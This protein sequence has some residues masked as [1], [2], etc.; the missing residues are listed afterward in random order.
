VDT[1][2]S[3][4]D[5]PSGTASLNI[6]GGEAPYSVNWQ[7]EDPTA[8]NQGAYSVTV[9]DDADCV[10]TNDFYIDLYPQPQA[11][12]EIDSILMINESYKLVNNSVGANVFNWDFNSILFNS[13]EEN[14][15][16]SYPEE[17]YFNISLSST[18]QY[19]CTDTVTQTIF[20]NRGIRLYSPN[21]FTPN[22]DS[23]NDRLNIKVLYFTSFQME[24]YSRSGELMFKPQDPLETW[25]GTFN[26]N[27][28]PM[29]TYIAVISANDLF[30]RVVNQQQ[31][32]NLIR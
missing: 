11:L 5:I 13:E 28:A 3:C 24:V 26:N 10:V 30:G 8:L 21:S 16:I 14:P 32:I 25:D 9:T 27:L 12:F 2:S 29:G 15:I 31:T 18:S 19:G 23:K 20:V 17:G 22:G 6:S 7:G 4:F 1:T